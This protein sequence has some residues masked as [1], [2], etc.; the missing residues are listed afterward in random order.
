MSAQ[1]NTSSLTTLTTDKPTTFRKQRSF[2]D[3]VGIG[4]LVVTFVA[5]VLGL[6]IGIPLSKRDTNS[7]GGGGGAPLSSELQRA[8]DLLTA[9]PL[10]DGWVYK[11]LGKKKNSPLDASTGWWNELLSNRPKLTTRQVKNHVC[12]LRY[13]SVMSRSNILRLYCDL[14]RITIT[15]IRFY[16]EFFTTSFTITANI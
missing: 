5:I 9:N 4:F 10:I 8:M 2:S 6:A 15:T 14:V 13:Y 1:F 16:L 7:G 11:V 12:R 3:R